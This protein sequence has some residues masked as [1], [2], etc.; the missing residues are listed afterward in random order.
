MGLVDRV[1]G[2]ERDPMAA[3]YVLTELG[4]YAAEYGEADFP[5]GAYGAAN[6]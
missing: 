6:D 5:P 2:S 4:K 1:T 3:T